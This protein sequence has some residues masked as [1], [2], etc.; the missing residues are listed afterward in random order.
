[1]YSFIH[2]FI[3]VLGCAKQKVTVIFYIDIDIS[4]N[5]KK[6]RCSAEKPPHFDNYAHVLY[7]C[8]MRAG[9]AQQKVTVIC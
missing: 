2:A 9:C 6:F 3:C 8:C 5:D 1:M 4:G 7:W